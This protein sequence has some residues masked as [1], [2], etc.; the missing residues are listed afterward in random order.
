MA[1]DLTLPSS[2]GSAKPSAQLA[3]HKFE[4]GDEGISGGYGIL[5]YKGKTWELSYRGQNYVFMREDGDGAR[6]S[7]DLVFIRAS[8]TKAKTYYPSY[9]EGAHDRPKCWSNDAIVPAPEVTEPQHDNC[10]QCPMNQVGSRVQDTGRP[11]RAC[12]DHK[13]TAVFIDPE[14]VRKA[15]GLELS[16]PVMLRIPGASLSEFANY[17]RFLQQRGGWPLVSVLTRI[18]FDPEQAFPKF[19]FQALRPLDEGELASALSLRDEPGIRR[20][21]LESGDFKAAAALPNT[22]AGKQ[23]PKLAAPAPKPL[24]APS[25]APQPAAKP[26]NVV[27]MKKVEAVA[28]ED[29]VLPKGNDPALNAALDAL[30]GK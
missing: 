29:D 19:K 11:S 27:Q 16:E 18:S 8:E 23:A 3:G 4:T 28:D 22:F 7:L 30:L 5:K 15:T 14:V 26:A 2:F 25:P 13:R 1:N 24:P 6:N 17:G 10:A 12:T 9:K 21:T 20:I